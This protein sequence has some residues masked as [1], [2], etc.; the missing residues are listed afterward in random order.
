MSLPARLTHLLERLGVNTAECLRSD[1][2]CSIS[3]EAGRLDIIPLPGKRA[4]LEALV[5]YLP[6]D[7]ARRR[8]SLEQA[9]RLSAAQMTVRP[10]VLVHMAEQD[11]LVLQH[12]FGLDMSVPEMESAVEQFLHAVDVWRRL[13]EKP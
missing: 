9:L 8:A 1:G 3:Y 11:A 10:D 13:C 2:R 4:L 6:P 5:T 12:E 7:P